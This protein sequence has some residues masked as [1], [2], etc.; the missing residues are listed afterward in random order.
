MIIR[1]KFYFI[2]IKTNVRIDSS[3]KVLRSIVNAASYI[4]NDEFYRNP[5]MEFVDSKIQNFARY[6]Q[7]RLLQYANGNPILGQ[8]KLCE[9]KK[10]FSKKSRP[11]KIV[12]QNLNLLFILL[13]SIDFKY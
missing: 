12:P 1:A 10:S 13:F 6:H 11:K 7:E 9:K 8:N 5:K 3:K 4:R 2:S